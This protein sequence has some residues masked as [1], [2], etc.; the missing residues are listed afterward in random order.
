VAKERDVNNVKRWGLKKERSD[1]EIRLE[2]RGERSEAD[3]LAKGEG[4]T[5]AGTTSR[6][7]RAFS[8]TSLLQ[9]TPG[10][11]SHITLLFAVTL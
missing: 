3:L 4:W 1:K 2:K 10:K 7:K 5:L 11:A 6:Q 9:D 8:V